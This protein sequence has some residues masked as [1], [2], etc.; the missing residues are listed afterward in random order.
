M[1][2][3]YFVAGAI[4][5]IAVA[6]SFRLCFAQSEKDYSESLQQFAVNHRLAFTP[7]DGGS[8]IRKL[9]SFPV[10]NEGRAHKVRNVISGRTAIGEVLIFDHSYMVMRHLL[11]QTAAI[12]ESPRQRTPNFKLHFERALFSDHIGIKFSQ[13]PKF[14]KCY[15][16]E[17]EDEA[18]IRK[19]FGEKS[20]MFF[21]TTPGL[22]L[23]SS[24]NYL[25]VYR[26]NNRLDGKDMEEFM[27]L[28]CDISVVLSQD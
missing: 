18:A 11:S 23:E 26:E 1:E 5:L 21:E 12:L 8:V 15:L 20:L 19:L 2:G 28:C 7:V 4:A 22:S 25:L 9:S 27:K 6:Y 14:S 3:L 17:G 24:N 10:F 13:R 16:L